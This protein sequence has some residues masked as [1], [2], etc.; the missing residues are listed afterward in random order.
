[1]ARYKV[2][3]IVRVRDNLVV[4]KRYHMDDGKT[5]DTFVSGMDVFLGKTVRI[6]CFFGKYFI[7]GSDKNWVD[8]MFEDAPVCEVGED[9]LLGFL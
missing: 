7:E 3:D 8:E 1:M 6:T 2:G 9:S 4:N 5:R